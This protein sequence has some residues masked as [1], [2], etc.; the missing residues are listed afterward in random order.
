MTSFTVGCW[1]YLQDLAKPSAVLVDQFFL[2]HETFAVT[3]DKGFHLKT[4]KNASDQFSFRFVV[5]N[6]VNAYSLNSTVLSRSAFA[7]AYLNRWTFVAATL[8]NQGATDLLNIYVDGTLSASFSVL[9]G[10]FY[11]SVDGV[12]R[13][14]QRSSVTNNIL[15]G[16]KM[17]AAFIYKRAL[18][19]SEIKSLYNEHRNKFRYLNNL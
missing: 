4:Q 15:A 1:V 11:T 17:E 14:M 2:G 12:I 6:G 7:S 9:A 13:M 19:A 8:K 10:S 16:N 18:G 3:T 5:T